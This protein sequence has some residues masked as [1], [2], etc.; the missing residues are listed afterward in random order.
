MCWSYPDAAESGSGAGLNHTRLESGMPSRD[1]YYWSRGSYSELEKALDALRQ[2]NRLAYRVV[3]ANHVG[4]LTWETDYGL[5]AL[6]RA[7]PETIFVPIIVS[8]AAGYLAP[9]AK[10]YAAPWDDELAA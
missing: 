9:Q 1:G 7:L 2:S 10:A 4:R 3:W 5:D 6:A 8:M